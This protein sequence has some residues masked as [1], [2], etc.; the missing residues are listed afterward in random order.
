MEIGLSQETN[1]VQEKLRRRTS[2]LHAEW[3]ICF[4]MWLQTFSEKNVNYG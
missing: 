2:Y 3:L 1:F 4:K